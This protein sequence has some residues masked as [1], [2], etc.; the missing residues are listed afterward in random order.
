MLRGMSRKC[1][2]FLFFCL[3]L[4]FLVGCGHDHRFAQHKVAFDPAWFGLNLMGQQNNLTGF[5]A[6]I[7]KEIGKL[8]NV[9][10][11]LVPVSWDTLAMNLR[12]KECDAI[13]S[14]VY[15]YLFNQTYFAFSS[16]YLLTGPVLVLP[17]D[18]KASSIEELSGKEIA[19]L[20]DTDGALY[21]EKNPDILIRNFETIPEALNAIVSGSVDGAVVDVLLASAYCKNIYNNIL[22]VATPPMGE[23]GVRLLVLEQGPSTLI[24]AF[25]EGLARLK[26]NG[27][28]QNL[29]EKWSLGQ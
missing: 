11:T 27:V 14:S 23:G 3:G 1:S 20:P 10:F 18:A 4:I 22:K 7:L 16:P 9:G 24:K 15:P 29:L 6:E 8:E 5:S 28:Y 13:L 21:L 19:V 17:I 26:K 12:N 25:D 2:K